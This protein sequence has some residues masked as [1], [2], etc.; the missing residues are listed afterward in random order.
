[1][2][3]ADP[4]LVR[5]ALAERDPLP[6]TAGFAGEIDG[7]LVRDVLGRQPLFS[8]RDDPETWSFDH[9]D[10]TDPISLPPGRVR[11]VTG[12]ESAADEQVWSL[13]SPP[14]ATD[15]DEALA[16]VRDAVFESV[17]AISDDGLAVAFSG[18]VDSAVVAAGVPDAPCYVVGFEGA[19]DIA[20]ARDAAD[21]MDRD[22]R[23]VELTHDAIE[24]AVPEIVAA[25]GRTNPMDVQIV[26]PLYLLAERVAADGYDRLAVGQG[27]DELFGGYA[28]VA[29]APDDPRVEAETVRGAAR[30]M[31]L[32]LPDQL[33]RDVLTLR[34][35]GVEPVAPLLDD[36]VVEAALPLPGELLVADGRR[37]IALR[38]AV[39]EILPESVAEAD[40]KAVQYGTYAS[41][42]LDRLARQAG[43][44]RRM[45]NHV[46]QYVESLLE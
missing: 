42:E 20:A 46:Q 38:T 35:A 26:L 33:E 17:N 32:T 7:R 40:K 10:L 12:D 41:R 1:M 11:T 21:T 19:H 29:K 3:G 5:R 39:A 27:A 8:E 28:K 18:G 22:L 6:G 25:L 34:A 9:R 37:K 23:V 30:E 36:R 4:E 31:V 24:R 14:A 44:K 16:T 15:T 43:Y 45:E 13:P 2:R